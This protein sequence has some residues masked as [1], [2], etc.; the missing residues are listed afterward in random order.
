MKNE[1]YP[2]SAAS[3]HVLERQGGSSSQVGSDTRCSRAQARCRAMGTM[4]ISY[5]LICARAGESYA[6]ICDKS[7][8]VNHCA[9]NDTFGTLDLDGFKLEL[10]PR[11]PESHSH[12]VADE[13]LDT[14]DSD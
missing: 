8:N 13:Y 2:L 4:M 14:S 9:L 1:R 3:W 6:V 11:F 10:D 7:N 5:L 12:M